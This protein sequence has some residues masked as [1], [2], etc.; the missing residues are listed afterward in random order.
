M[1]VI[2]DV[3][4][5]RTDKRPWSVSGGTLIPFIERVAYICR[6]HIHTV[7]TS[8]RSL[9]DVIMHVFVNPRT[10]CVAWYMPVIRTDGHGPMGA[11]LD[12]SMQTLG[13]IQWMVVF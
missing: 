8:G 1:R 2:L 10:Y 7:A 13:H 4:C 5:I 11:S 3:A 12:V 9:V 6:S